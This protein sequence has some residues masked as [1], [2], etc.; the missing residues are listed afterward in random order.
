MSRL[1]VIAAAA[2]IVALV[3]LTFHFH[4][5][6]DFGMDGRALVARQGH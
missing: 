2:T 4:V 5:N 1:I 6:A 3:T